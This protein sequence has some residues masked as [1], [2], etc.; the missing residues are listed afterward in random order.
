[1]LFAQTTPEAGDE[2]PAPTSQPAESTVKDRGLASALIGSKHD[3]RHGDESR[4]LCVACHSPHVMALASLPHNRWPP[5]TQPLRAYQ[6]T[7]VELDRASLLCVSC[8]DGV[9]AP[10]VYTSAHATQ[11]A[12]QAGILSSGTRGF[13][14]HPIGIAYPTADP[15]FNSA[16]SVLAG[17]AIKLPDGRIQCTSCHDPHN[18]RGFRRMLVTSNA[19]SR[20]CLTCHRL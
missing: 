9:I 5:T 11:F 16:A 12:D 13:G 19:R 4:D 1:L 14:S 2:K 7:G 15:K 3:L 20:L 8:H 10:D 17:G 18:T 6:T